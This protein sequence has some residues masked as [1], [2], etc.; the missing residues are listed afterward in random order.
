MRGVLLLERVQNS[1]P[2][3]QLE[4]AKGIDVV[5]GVVVEKIAFGPVL[6]PAR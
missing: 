5:C 2:D 4:D 1:S 3:G 6:C